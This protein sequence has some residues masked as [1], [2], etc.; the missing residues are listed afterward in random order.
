MKKKIGFI[1]CPPEDILKKYFDEE[2]IDI[3]DT[4]SG[5][6]KISATILPSTT[7]SI[8]KRIVDN[9]LSLK[10]D[11]IIF[12]EGYGKCDEARA[13]GDILSDLLDIEI[14]K[15]RNNNTNAKGTAI[16]DSTLAPLEKAELI[17]SSL[18]K[19]ITIPPIVYEK[20]PPAAV[21]GVP[22]SDFNIYSLFPE[23]TKILGWF[24]CLENRTPA[25]H[26]L[27]NYVMPNVPT[28]FLS[29]S[30]CHK[31]IQAK[32]LARKHKGLYVDIEGKMTHSVRAKIEAFLEFKVKK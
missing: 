4:F 1:G 5:V 31:N 3:D 7:C 25:D 15:T 23:G 10:L 18:S 28:V 21:W 24:R 9:A 30:F 12:D 8:V 2:L 32:Y 27:E 16:S 19:K 29:Q 14:I 17:V 22:A 26:K 20:K 6:E 13:A 11:K